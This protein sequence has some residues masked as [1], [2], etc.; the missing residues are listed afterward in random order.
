MATTDEQYAKWGLQTPQSIIDTGQAQGG[1]ISFVAPIRA[2]QAKDQ[3]ANN[4]AYYAAGWIP[5]QDGPGGQPWKTSQSGGYWELG[6]GKN[7]VYDAPVAATDGEVDSAPSGAGYRIYDTNAQDGFWS[8]TLK[9]FA[10]IAAVIAPAFGGVASGAI[11]TGAGAVADQMAAGALT[12]AATSAMGGGNPLTGALT[13]AAG[14]AV[15]GFSSQLEGGANFVGPTQGNVFNPSNIV[16]ATGTGLISAVSGGNPLVAGGSSLA[17]SAVANATGSPI[18]GRLTGMATGLVGSKLSG[19]KATP[20]TLPTVVSATPSV[21][22]TTNV[23]DWLHGLPETKSG[24]AKF[25][26]VS[27]NK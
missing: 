23:N 7:V 20:T 19:S 4:E 25:A 8:S 12:G 1:T 2:E 9:G 14:G 10:P 13:G 17:S 6:D 21:S 18:A 5:G 11:N 15:G 3:L 24:F 22:N 16:R 27:L 26:N